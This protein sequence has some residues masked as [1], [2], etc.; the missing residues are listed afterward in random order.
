MLPE[1]CQMDTNRHQSVHIGSQLIFQEIPVDSCSTQSKRTNPVRS[2]V[3][4]LYGD[5]NIL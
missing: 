2:L 4:P 3:H 1:T 5:L